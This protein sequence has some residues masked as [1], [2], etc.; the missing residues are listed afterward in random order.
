M[1][2]VFEGF[3]HRAAHPMAVM[4]YRCTEY[5]EWGYPPVAYAMDATGIWT[6]KEYIQRCN[7]TIAA[8]VTFGS[9]YELCNGAERIP[10][11]SRLMRWWYQ[12]VGREEE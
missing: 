11:P 2:K 6:I 5:R 7:F 12:Y 4:T 8:Q 10:G 3:H 9:I 1:L